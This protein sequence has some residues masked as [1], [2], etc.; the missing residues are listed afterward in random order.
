MCETGSPGKLKRIQCMDKQ[1]FGEESEDSFDEGDASV[2]IVTRFFRIVI[3]RIL[4]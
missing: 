1:S 2:G 4:D 3:K